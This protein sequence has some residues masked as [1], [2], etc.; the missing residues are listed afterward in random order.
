[1]VFKR[2]NY[3][4]PMELFQIA[5]LNA[6]DR[7]VVTCARCHHWHRVYPAQL[8]DRYPTTLPIVD[9]LKTFRCRGCRASG[10]EYAQWIVERAQHGATLYGDRRDPFTV[11]DLTT[12]P[13]PSS[14]RTPR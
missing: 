10:K 4:G 2:L 12:D 7:V 14:T 5:D 13:K 8:I 9:V 3:I 6:A 11:P 1:M